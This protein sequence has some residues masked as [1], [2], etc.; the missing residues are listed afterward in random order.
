LTH[1]WFFVALSKA[2]RASSSLVGVA[3]I[4]GLGIATAT[5]AVGCADG[6]TAISGV[7]RA[8]SSTVGVAI[9]GGLGVTAAI[10][11]G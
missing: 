6:W 1:G 5:G 4:D 10:G 9:A 8:F 2:L 11:A 7:G 3:L